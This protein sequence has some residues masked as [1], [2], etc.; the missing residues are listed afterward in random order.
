MPPSFGM[1]DATG[2]PSFSR[3]P[4][5]PVADAAHRLHLTVF[6][7]VERTAIV[8]EAADLLAQTHGG[9]LDSVPFAVVQIP[10]AGAVAIVKAHHAKVWQVPVKMTN[11]ALK[12]WFPEAGI[13]LRF[14]FR[15][16]VLV[17]GNAQMP[18]RV[19]SLNTAYRQPQW[20]GKLVKSSCSMSSSG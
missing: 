13:A 20:P 3:T 9:F 12:L 7:T 6:Q 16:R 2:A 17:V 15:D 10:K 8:E 14:F 5:I 18:R 11:F 1:V 19:A 4:V